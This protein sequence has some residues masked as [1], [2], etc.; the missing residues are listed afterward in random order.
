MSSLGDVQRIIPQGTTVSIDANFQN[1]MYGDVTINGHLDNDG[2]LV[3]INGNVLGTGSVANAGNI[4]LIDL[5]EKHE[6]PGGDVQYNI[7]TGSTVSLDGDYQHL[8]YG[9]LIVDGTL[10]T[11]GGRITVLNGNLLLGGIVNLQGT[12]QL[13]IVDL[14]PVVGQGLTYSNGIITSLGDVQY[15][16]PAGTTVSLHGDYQH[17][18]YGDL[19]VDGTL[20]NTDGKIT[21][22]NG[23]LKGNGNVYLSGSASLEVVDLAYQESLDSI[24]IGQGLTGGATNGTI[25]VASLG[26]VQKIIPTGETVSIDSNFQNFM[27]GNIQIDGHL[28]VDGELVIINGNITGGGTLDNNGDITLLELAEKNYII[29]GQGLTGSD[30]QGDQLTFESLGDVQYNIPAGSTVSLHGDYQHLVYGDLTIEGTLI[31][32]GGKVVLLDGGLTGSGD[33]LL[34]GGAELEFVDLS[35]VDELNELVDVDITGATTGQALIYDGNNWIA[36]TIST[37]LGGLEDVETEGATAGYTLIYDGVT[38]SATELPASVSAGQGL[39]LSNDAVMSS[40]GD[41]QKVIPTG[42]TVYVGE[43]YQHLVLGDLTVDGYLDNDG[44]VT[45][46]NG[47]LNGTGSVANFGN[48]QIVNFAEVGYVNDLVDNIEGLTGSVGGTISVGAS[49]GLSVD[50]DVQLGGDLTKNTTIDGDGYDLTIGSINTL[51]FTSS[52]MNH[53]S[54]NNLI[55]SVENLTPGITYSLISQADTSNIISSSTYD[56][57]NPPFNNG[58]ISRFI[59]SAELGTIMEI[60]EG[61][62]GPSNN[63]WITKSDMIV[64]DQINSKG[65]EY[66]TDY[67]GN[68]TTH[69]LVTKKYVDNSLQA[70][71]NADNGLTDIGGTISLGGTLSQ[72]TTIV[73]NDQDLAINEL[74]SLDI[75]TY[76]T[77]GYGGELNITSGN[78]TQTILRA[79]STSA[80]NSF[81]MNI[82]DYA[83]PNN[84]THNPFVIED[85]S[86]GGNGKGAVYAD[87]YSSNF[88]PESLISR[89]YID[90]IQGLTGSA[91]NVYV[92]FD[93]KKYVSINS[94]TASVAITHI[95]NLGEDIVVN[96]IDTIN[97]ERVDAKVSN[98]TS[99]S[100]NVTFT[101]NISDVKVVIIG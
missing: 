13:E 87:D 97:D 54:P 82:T 68:F 55:R 84:G 39:T 1:F 90:N 25:E 37:T 75:D 21:I 42:A 73:G 8:V 66:A 64:S 56:T 69:S 94:Y 23:D 32:N 41:V 20:Y 38:W 72:P 26:D 46:I 70:T 28:D 35:A 93:S 36:G 19:T 24:I 85:N 100:V 95:H 74:N 44:K 15:N 86:N 12:A 88:T 18:V 78:T 4:K 14:N 63:I 50:G 22:L 11:N 77:L 16:I 99:T 96:L 52:N 5:A 2:E 61:T 83:V 48:V 40:L 89:R 65:L 49:N 29:T 101:Q 17:L 98:Y 30:G 7:G 31:A 10:T 34:L 45:I 79:K 76:D 51:T 67:T 27:Y 71:V 60:K 33:L 80:T 53:F 91:P 81:I 47:S 6:L 58:A 57:L 9:D 59:T 62:A 3:V 92:D 43:D